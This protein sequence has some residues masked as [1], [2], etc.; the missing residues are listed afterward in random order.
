MVLVLIVW[1]YLKIKCA[2]MKTNS[3]FHITLATD[4]TDYLTVL[5]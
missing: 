3:L 1:M 4:A 5:S 2:I